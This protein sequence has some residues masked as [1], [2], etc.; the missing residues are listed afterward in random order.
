M[1]R[2]TILFVVASLGVGIC[3]LLYFNYK[4]PSWD[5]T[6]LQNENR[7]L[8][9]QWKNLDD[10]VRQASTRLT[11]LENSDDNTY[12]TILDLSPL[13]ST[14]RAA[15]VGGHENEAAN[16]PYATI[17]NAYEKVSK[18]DARLGIEKQSFDDLLGELHTKEKKWASTPALTPIA[19]KD[20][21]RRPQL[22]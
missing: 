12:R 22:G 8:M 17:R 2:R 11:T 4:Y 3:G 13:D 19:N 14:E 10:Q 1:F 7:V 21:I 16:V 15:G 20:L 9:A 5:E 6:E 18:L